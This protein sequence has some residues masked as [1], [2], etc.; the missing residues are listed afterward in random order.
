[1]YSKRRAL[2]GKRSKRGQ[3]VAKTNRSLRMCLSSWCPGGRYATVSALDII[4]LTTVSTVVKLSASRKVK[5]RVSSV[6]LGLTA[7]PHMILVMINLNMR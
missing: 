1:V 7:R 5:G 2:K 6:G 4:W 3:K